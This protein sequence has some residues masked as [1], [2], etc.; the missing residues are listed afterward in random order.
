MSNAHKQKAYSYVRFSTPEQAKG[1]SL[2]RQVE[3]S[4]RYAREHGL[5]LDDRLK[6][7]DP[8]KSAFK[9]RNLHD[10]ALGLFIKAVESGRIKRGS[11]LLIENLD[12]LS[13]LPVRKAQ[14][15]LE[16]ILELGI[17][18]VT[19]HDR[20]VYTE[21]SI[22]ANFSDLMYALM[23]LQLGHEESAK[24]SERVRAAKAAARKRAI[25][26][27]TPMPGRLPA[28]VVK[29]TKGKLILHPERAEVVRRIF[30]EALKGHGHNYITRMLTRENV[31]PIGGRSPYWNSTY[32]LNILKDPAVITCAEIEGHVVSGYYPRVVSDSVFYRVKDL[33]ASRAKNLTGGPSFNGS[34][35]GGNLFGHGL[36]KC[37]LCDSNMQ[38]V[39][40]RADLAYLVC[41]RARRGGGCV[42]SSWR[43]GD[44]EDSL[45][46]AISDKLDWSNLDTHIE[47]H[48]RTEVLQLEENYAAL[49]TRS[50]IVEKRRKAFSIA[51]DAEIADRGS[52]S[53]LLREKLHECE[54]EWAQVTEEISSAQA[55][56]TVEKDKQAHASSTAK[57]IDKAFDEWRDKRRH[58]PKDRERLRQ[59]LRE[60]IRVIE[61]HADGREFDGSE[62]RVVSVWFNHDGEQE[63]PGVVFRLPSDIGFKG[64]TK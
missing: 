1:D 25:Q 16:H 26:H 11:Y 43:L 39:V 18:I 55:R 58:N 36:A 38:K 44:L 19:L 13:R 41:G 21:A 35:Q 34:D 33:R 48:S 3:L 62:G 12:R 64:E 46:V 5:V 61:F 54:Q 4:E 45:L 42:Y 20:K 27:G 51:I 56:L 60:L 59:A 31:P 32:V 7:F 9:G 10:G 40:K 23:H 24:K 49:R 30:R 22:D 28:W 47:A 53:P 52:I 63:S 6:F 15:H 57:A 14:R 37:A 8:A 2:R 17:S 29:D 50:E